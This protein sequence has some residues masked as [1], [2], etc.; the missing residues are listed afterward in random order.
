MDKKKSGL[1]DGVQV[2]KF[3]GTFL[4]YQFSNRCNKKDIGLHQDDDLTVFKNKSGPQVQVIKNDFQNIFRGIG[5][6]IVTCNLKIYDYL[7]VTLNLLNNTQCW[8]Q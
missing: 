3:F 7:D 8:I 6:N 1:F 2:C 4:F 5:L